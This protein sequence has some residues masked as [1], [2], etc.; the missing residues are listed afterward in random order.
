MAYD[1]EREEYLAL[2]TSQG[3]SKPNYQAGH[4]T[5][6]GRTSAYLLSLFALNPF[7]I[8]SVYWGFVAQRLKVLN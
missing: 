1:A 7:L 8:Q 4:I 6:R 2:C 3:V 5:I